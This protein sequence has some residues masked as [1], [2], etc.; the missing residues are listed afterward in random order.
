MKMEHAIISDLPY[1]LQVAVNEY[2]K[3]KYFKQ[4]K[5]FDFCDD[6]LLNRLC[7][8]LSQ[9][10]YYTGDV[11]VHFGDLG[12]EMYFVES[13]TVEVVSTDL[14]T[15]FAK[16]DAG[17][18]FGETGLVYRSRRTANIRAATICTCYILTKEDFDSE[19]Q[20]CNIEES[21]AATS[22]E[23][24]Q[25]ANAR[26]NS[27][28]IKNLAQCTNPTF[29]LSRILGPVKESQEKSWLKQ[30]VDPDG[31]PKQCL[32]GLGLLFL[33]YYIFTI[34]FEVAFLFGDHLTAY[35]T[36]V[37]PL[38]F[39]VDFCCIVELL[40]RV[41]AFPLG[42]QQLKTTERTRLYA[43]KASLA[44]DVIGSLPL[45]IFAA[46]PG[47][48]LYSICLFRMVH[49]TRLMN[50]FPRLNQVEGHLVR[51]G[52]SWHR[53]TILVVKSI[54]LY[55]LVNHW[56]AC[57]FFI[58]HRVQPDVETWAVADGYST[59]DKNDEYHD[60]CNTEIGKCYLRALYFVAGVLTSVGYGTILIVMD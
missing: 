20:G 28:V 21:A 43:T 5:F 10:N 4:C 3:M 59:F 52:L 29:K 8:R 2:T 11:I 51:N 49:L 15:V 42:F 38:D 40:L 44:W 34:P 9:A 41:M 7:M 45:E 12:Q 19:L 50:F 1:S 32:D 23:R 30:L 25:T 33:F 47:L 31:I 17:G 60:I 16:I 6:S 39:V 24:L 48:G 46:I 26:M 14:K 53:T 57:I 56:F 27:A 55:V 54:L 22:L 13:G 18:F 36:H 35:S 58:V 37:M